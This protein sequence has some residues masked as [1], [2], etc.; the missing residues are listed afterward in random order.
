MISLL[1]FTCFIPFR[2]LQYYDTGLYHLQAIKWFSSVKL[3][4][5]LANLIS[6]IGFNSSWFTINAIVDQPVLLLKVPFFI[7]NSICIFYYGISIVFSFKELIKKTTKLSNI[8]A[9]LTIMPW[10]LNAISSS[11]SSSAPDSPV[12]FYT[13]LIIILIM[14]LFEEKKDNGVCFIFITALSLFAITLKISSVVLILAIFIILLIN[15][16]S[17]NERFLQRNEVISGFLFS[18]FLIPWIITGIFISGYLMF[19]I[20]FSRINSLNWAVPSKIARDLQENIEIWAKAPGTTKPIIFTNYHWFK[21][22]ITR[23]IINNKII[24]ILIIFLL[25]LELFYLIKKSRNKYLLNYKTS[26]R[27]SLIISIAGAI[28]WFLNAPD[29]R[30]GSG[31]VFSVL[32]ILISYK[33][34]SMDMINNLYSF[35]LKIKNNKKHNLVKNII[36]AA[37]IFILV[38]AFIFLFFKK[39]ENPLLN[40]IS[41]IRNKEINDSWIVKLKIIFYIFLISG[42]LIIFISTFLFKKKNIIINNIIALIFILLLNMVITKTYFFY[43]KEFRG[44][45]TANKF[46][47]VPLKIKNTQD[48]HQILVPIDS[49]QVWDSPLFSTAEFNKDLKIINDGN[50]SRIKFWIEK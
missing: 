40:I 7:S 18:L 44:Y 4:I 22:W 36:L 50:N 48:N 46:S 5:G 8:F 25:I 2:W 20:N 23:F 28:F 31:F 9:A 10:M 30:F 13:F 19:P 15:Y 27:F 32:L 3:P 34:Y 17:K 1:I 26:Y 33:I 38:L 29:I 12:I 37:G 11:S 14:S 49:D 41:I 42:I 21:D 35:L 39:L 45:P 43:F 6:R 47:D 24:V 16:F